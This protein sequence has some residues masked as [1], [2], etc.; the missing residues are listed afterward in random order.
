MAIKAISQFDAATPTSNDKILFEQNGEGKSTTLANLP[1]STKTQTALDTKVNTAN[2][3]T[4]EEIMKT[5]DLSGKVASASAF[6]KSNARTENIFT[7]KYLANGS[8]SESINRCKEMCSKI[9]GY[10]F[11]TA[12]IQSD[13]TG[14]IMGFSYGEYTENPGYAS[15]I[16]LPIL[17]DSPKIVVCNNNT[18]SVRNI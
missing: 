9:P 16:C 8:L 10:T 6:K 5:T 18:W 2:V 3:L 15:F 17:T 12:I 4:Y 1:I 14:M 13:G 7:L 11:S